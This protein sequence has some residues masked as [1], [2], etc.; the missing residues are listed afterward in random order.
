MCE[1]VSRARDG[2]KLEVH[3]HIQYTLT[4]THM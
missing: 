3:K 1:F 2:R 4:L